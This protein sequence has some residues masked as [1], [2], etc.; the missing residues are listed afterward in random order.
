MFNSMLKHVCVFL[1]VCVS[2]GLIESQLACRA[3]VW[4]SFDG[5]L[6]NRGT[7]INRENKHPT[8]S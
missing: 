8:A 2:I 7:G 1:C 4:G 6:D 5:A 3:V